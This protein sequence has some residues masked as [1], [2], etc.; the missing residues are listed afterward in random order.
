VSTTAGRSKSGGCKNKSAAFAAALSAIT[1]KNLKH[2]KK[3]FIMGCPE[4]PIEYF[5]EVGEVAGNDYYGY[6]FYNTDLGR[7]ISRDPIENLVR[8]TNY[9]GRIYC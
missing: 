9:K 4:L 2:N 7:W 3:D 8:I 5:A 6:R 1:W